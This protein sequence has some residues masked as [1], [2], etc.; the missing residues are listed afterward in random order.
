LRSRGMSEIRT[1][2]ETGARDQG[3]GISEA[4]G[5]DCFA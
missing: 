5:A 1:R 3:L 4:F 2:S